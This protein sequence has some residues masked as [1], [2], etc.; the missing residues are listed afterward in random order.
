MCFGQA[1][2]EEKFPTDFKPPHGLK[3]YEPNMDPTIWIEN[4]AMAMSIQNTS[5][6]T[7]TRYL[8]MMLEGTTRTW[9]NNLPRNNVNS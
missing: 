2:V 9:I 6:H 7:E 8:P 3:N 1:I 4:Y 5:S